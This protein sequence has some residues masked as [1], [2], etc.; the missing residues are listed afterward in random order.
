[1]KVK[2]CTVLL[3]VPLVYIRIYLKISCEIGIFN[4]GQLSAAHSKFSEQGYEDP[5]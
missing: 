3:S 1:M 2:S 4:F 5:W